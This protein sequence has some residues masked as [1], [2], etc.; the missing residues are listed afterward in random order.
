M[1]MFGGF[2]GPNRPY[3]NAVDEDVAKSK[4]KEKEQR[5]HR[6]GPPGFVRESVNLLIAVGVLVI[7]FYLIK[8]LA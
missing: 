5:L 1:D 4:F 6:H 3:M 7:V 8:W 2:D